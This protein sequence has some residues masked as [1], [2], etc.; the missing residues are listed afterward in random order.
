MTNAVCKGCYGSPRLEIHT[1]AGAKEQ[2]WGRELGNASQRR[3]S[4]EQNLEVEV[5]VN[6]AKER[7]RKDISPKKTRR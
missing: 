5:G 3:L 6:Q 4:L 1:P 7:G 2:D